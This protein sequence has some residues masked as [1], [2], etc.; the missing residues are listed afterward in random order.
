VDPDAVAAARHRFV[1]A[2][3]DD[4]GDQ[5]VEA[6]LIRAAN[7]HTGASADRFEALEDLD[8]AGC[9]LFFCDFSVYCHGGSYRPVNAV[10][11]GAWTSFVLKG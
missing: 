11:S 9:V 6:A 1:D 4:L 2:V 7:V 3:V 8:I 10:G 5:L